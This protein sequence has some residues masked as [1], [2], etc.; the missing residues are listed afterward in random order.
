MVIQSVS[1]RHSG[2]FK[3]TASNQAGNTSETAHF[4]VKGSAYIQIIYI[5]YKISKIHNH[6]V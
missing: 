3:C 6:K 1:P 4:S 5:F 2:I